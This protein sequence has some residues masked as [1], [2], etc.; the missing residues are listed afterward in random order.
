MSW[1]RNQIEHTTNEVP[2]RHCCSYSLMLSECKY[3]SNHYLFYYDSISVHNT[4][5]SY[6]GFYLIFPFSREIDKNFSWFLLYSANDYIL[7]CTWLLIEQYG[8]TSKESHPKTIYVCVIG[9]EWHTLHPSGW[10]T[11]IPIIY[12][13]ITIKVMLVCRR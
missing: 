10:T 3:Y 12:I 13:S 2:R 6:L 1:I 4:M 5:E 8:C 11:D 7:S 9:L